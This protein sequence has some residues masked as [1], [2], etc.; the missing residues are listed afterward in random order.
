MASHR[1]ASSL[2]SIPNPQT[3]IH[4]LKGPPLLEG[5]PAQQEVLNRSTRY[6]FHPVG[7]KRRHRFQ[8]Q[9]EPLS[10]TSANVY[11]PALP[12]QHRPSS[13]ETRDRVEPYDSRYVYG[14]SCRVRAKSYPKRIRTPL[15]TPL[16]G[17]PVPSVSRDSTVWLCSHYI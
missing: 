17:S 10:A 14:V 11:M 4:K 13:P 6:S 5:G 8:E 9:A 16:D 3:T 15:F 7:A 1:V 12:G 2:H